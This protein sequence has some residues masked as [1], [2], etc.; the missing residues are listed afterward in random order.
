MHT[1]VA[2][3]RPLQSPAA[4]SPVSTCEVHPWLVAVSA[5]LP[6][7]CH[8]TCTSQQSLGQC[9]ENTAVVT[10]ASQRSLVPASLDGCLSATHFNAARFHKTSPM[11]NCLPASHTPCAI[12]SDIESSNNNQLDVW[13]N[14]K[15]ISVLLTWL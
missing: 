9:G 3:R 7:F 2:L 5:L 15:Y 1:V 4:P 12:N 13:I 8:Q 10:I 14:S 6:T 11:T